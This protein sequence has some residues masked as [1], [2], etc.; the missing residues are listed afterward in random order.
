M[1][2]I[3]IGTVPFNEAIAF[4]RGKLKIPTGRWDDMLGEVHAK[5]F[6]VA[7]ATKADL[8]T[9]LHNAVT[10]AI[11]NGTTITE[12]R[13]QFDKAVTEHG[14]SY[15]GKRGWRTRVIYDTNMRT[16]RMAG[17]WQQFQRL[18]QT[19]PYL[20]YLTV[21]DSHVR[22]EHQSWDRIVLPIDDPWW[23]T[24]YPPNGWGCR[25]TVRSVSLRQIRKEKL[26][27]G[28]APAIQQTE[29][30]N[31]S[32][33]EIYGFVPKGID[34][35]WNYNVGKAWLGPDIA[36]GEKIMAMPKPLMAAALSSAK[37]LAPELE[38]AFSPWVDKLLSSKQSSGEI[39]TIG[40]L[41]PKVID[42]LTSRNQLPT[43][44][45]ITATDKQIMHMIRD[46]KDG[47]HIPVDTIKDL[48]NVIQTARAVLWDKRNPALLYVFDVPDQVRSG[49]I[50]IRVNYKTKGRSEDGQRNAVLTN[51]LRSGGLVETRNL[52]DKSIYD[53]IE[54]EL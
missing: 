16:A 52:A 6:T 13:K 48:P 30:I 17:K 37:K 3:N 39:K 28:Q 20:Q 18:K 15:K 43:T 26:D 27:I 53:V 2:D 33:G 22:P 45:V 44:A 50:V 7:G 5:A 40:Y 12:F 19:R 10:D 34:T 54:G 35:G 31:A 14:W 36:F 25:C 46:A 4:F 29:R 9:D 23:S 21:G 38:K 11:T 47:K 49:K 42:E 41:S 24:H 51:S 8:L 32:T 1:P